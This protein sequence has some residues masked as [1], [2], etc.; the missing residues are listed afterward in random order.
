MNVHLIYLTNLVY[1]YN[2]KRAYKC[3]N[4]RTNS[5]SVRYY[6]TNS[7]VLII[8]IS[9]MYEDGPFDTVYFRTEICRDITSSGD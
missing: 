5:F 8:L 6:E 3:R 2:K 7:N 9:H 1:G 4:T